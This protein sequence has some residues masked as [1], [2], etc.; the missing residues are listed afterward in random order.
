MIQHGKIPMLFF[1]KLRFA[2]PISGIAA[3]AMLDVC[4][5]LYGHLD[6]LQLGNIQRDVD[7]VD[8]ML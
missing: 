7:I 5:P 1:Y 8:V 6:I 4:L 2:F 3:P